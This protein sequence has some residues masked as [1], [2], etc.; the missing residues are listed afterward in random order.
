M[1]RRWR[2]MIGAL[3][4]W[5]SLAVSSPPGGLRVV[6]VDRDEIQI[7]GATVELC[8]EALIGGC[9]TGLTD[10]WGAALFQ[11]L[12]PG[13]YT[14]SVSGEPLR[15]GVRLQ[16]QPAGAQIGSHRIAQLVLEVTPVPGDAQPAPASDGHLGDVLSGQH[17]RRIPSEALA[18]GPPEVPQVPGPA[19]IAGV[20]GL[21]GHGSATREAPAPGGFPQRGASA[22]ADTPFQS[23]PR[24]ERHRPGG[25]RS[26]AERAQVALSQW[27]AVSGPAP[28]SDAPGDPS[29]GLRPGPSAYA[30][31]RR[32]LRAG[33]LPE[34]DRIEVASFVD[35]MPCAPA[36]VAGSGPSGVQ[37]EIVRHPRD[38]EQRLLLRVGLSTGVPEHALITAGDVRI[39][40][41]FS[42]DAVLG[43]RLLG[44]EAH[45]PGGGASEAGALGARQQLTAL[46]DLALAPAPGPVLA[47]VSVRAGE[48]GPGA[49]VQGLGIVLETEP[50]L[51][52]LDEGG[53]DTLVAYAAA[54]FAELLQGSPHV[55]GLSYG[56]V[57][58]L[59][60][61]AMDPGQRA[62]V[63]LLELVRLA[64]DLSAPPPSA[65]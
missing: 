13:R 53:A 44:H 39:G 5:P 25:G 23:I 34:P 2:W 40:V 16:G 35:A 42:G 26:G 45:A 51:G 64:E 57:R 27:V 47:E 60:Q 36:P 22:Q 29:G 14:A 15:G 48:P 1:A 32:S 21:P 62:H 30:Y 3:S 61:V 37:L 9:T 63:E 18:Q 65:P 55:L 28:G 43:W 56:D 4:L 19:P 54:T 24:A 12:P 10:T 59:L 41:T 38:P 52:R 7:F 31:A 17:L 50:V 11:D 49:P 46:Y 20:P 58:Q 33:R 6:V 8:G